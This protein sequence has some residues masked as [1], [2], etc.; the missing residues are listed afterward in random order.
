[1]V[2]ERGILGGLHMEVR[3]RKK[4]RMTPRFLHIGHVTQNLSRPHMHDLEL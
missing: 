2:D 1:M 3:E 4:S